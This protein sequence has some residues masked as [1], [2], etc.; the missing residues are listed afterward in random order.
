MH[1]AALVGEGHVGT[2]KRVIGDGLSEYFHT[3]H[4]GDYFF[5]FALQIWVDECNMV[6]SADYIAEGGKA[7]F[8]S[9]AGVLASEG[10]SHWASKPYLYLDRVW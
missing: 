2:Y 9:L 8:Y 7:F 3:K 4:I 5:G 10:V 6:I 1:Y